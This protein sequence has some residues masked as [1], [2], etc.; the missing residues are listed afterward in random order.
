[1]VP[2]Q[3]YGSRQIQKKAITL[4]RT[5]YRPGK[6]ELGKKNRLGATPE[7]LAKAVMQDAGIKCLK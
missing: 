5:D 6:V 2:N 4:K 3:K 7:E 1:M